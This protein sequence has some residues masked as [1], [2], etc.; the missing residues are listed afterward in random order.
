MRRVVMLLAA[1]LIALPGLVRAQDTALAAKIN[2]ITSRPEFRHAMWGIKIVDL[3]AKTT[4]YEMNAN[5]L[6]FPASTTKLLTMGTA[7]ALLGPDFRFRTNV[8]AVGTWGPNG[9]LNGDLVI[10]ASGDPNLSGRIR[11]DGTLAFE[12]ED[13]AYAG[14][15]SMARAV[16]G[17]PLLVIKEMAK[18]AAS[19]VKTLNGRVLVDVSMFPEGQAEGGSGVIMSP[20]M[21]NDN[22]I[23]ITITPS[24]TAGAPMTFVASPMTAYATFVNKTVTGAAGSANT[25]TLASDSVTPEGNHVVTV[26]GSLPAHGPSMLFPYDVP[27]PSRF[28]AVTFTEALTAAGTKVIA[29]AAPAKPDWSK[30]AASYTPANV[31]AE[32]VSPPYSEEVKVTL[33][34]S[35]NLHAAVT[36]YILGAVIG[37]KDTAKT[38]FD[39]EREF[40]TKGGL[41]LSGAQQADGLGADDHFTPDFMVS[42][43]SWYTTL[44]T[45]PVFLKALP[46]L[47]RDGTLYNIQTTSPAAGHIFAKTGTFASGDPLNKDLLVTAKGLAGYITTATGRHLVFAVYVNNVAVPGGDDVTKI[48]GQ[49]V[50]AV[51]AAAY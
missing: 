30:L 31:V 11:P 32:H 51:A 33:K 4:L 19:K 7:L 17:D 43:L 21:V 49:A 29:P 45:Y 46:I 42:Y 25:I 12:N 47:G 44:P 3:D 27:L 26:T 34:V 6:F 36:H 1:T 16:P 50:G 22:I 48:V 40:L 39:L 9:T 24:A 41:D 15:D 37:K 13:H 18:Q 5:K 8:Y 23:D 20:I 28:A 35:D 38:G 10:V 2:A 14:N